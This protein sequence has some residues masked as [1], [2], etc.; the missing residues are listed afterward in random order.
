MARRPMTWRWYGTPAAA[1]RSASGGIR[2]GNAGHAVVALHPERGERERDEVVLTDREDEI[3]EL[4]R[5][6]SLAQRLPCR[7]G[8]GAAVVQLVHGAEQGGIAGRPSGCI[9]PGCDALD[10]VVADPGPAGDRDVLT[11]FVRCRAP[12]SRAKDDE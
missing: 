6:V 5:V 7:V 12:P 3:H 10:L 2:E 8:D 9:G 1:N 11:P 4:L